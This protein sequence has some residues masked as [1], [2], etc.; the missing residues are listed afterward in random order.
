MEIPEPTK[1]APFTPCVGAPRL[2]R[3]REVRR[4]IWRTLIEHNKLLSELT[5]T[6]LPL[7]PEMFPDTNGWPHQLYIRMARRMMG[8]T[9]ITQA[10]LACQTR[11]KTPVGLGYYMVDI[12][13]CRLVVL[14]DGVL[15][16]EGE[17]WE[18][19]SPGPYPIPYG[20]LTPRR[21]ECENLL[22]SVCV[23]ASHVACS[24]LRMEPTYMLLGESAGIAAAQAADES[25]IVQDI[26]SR[27]FRA[28][29]R[30]AGQILD[31]D[32]EGYGAWWFNRPVEPWWKKH[33]EEYETN[34]APAGL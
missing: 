28:S 15:A 16:T 32:G 4:R 18:L 20:A 25:G 13:P 24:S 12:Y 1:R 3:R 11:V 23:S 7:H 34:P 6:P 26:D 14:D 5:G 31:W 19:V 27:R 9:V 33:P 17:T 2:D 29:L 10:D 21:E 8:E 22:V 30:R